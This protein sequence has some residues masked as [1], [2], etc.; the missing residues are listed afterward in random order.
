MAVV[1]LDTKGMCCPLPLLKAKKA[2]S[3]M[4]SGEQLKVF[5]TDRGSVRDFRV[6]AEKSGHRLVFSDEQD[7]VYVHLLEKV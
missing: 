1:E 6:Y 7:G 2:L 4:A 5:A 3:G